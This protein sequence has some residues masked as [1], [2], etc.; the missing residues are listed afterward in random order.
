MKNEVLRNGWLMKLFFFWGGWDDIVHLLSN[1]IIVAGY[2]TVWE[3]LEIKDFYGGWYPHQLLFF[4]CSPCKTKSF[5]PGSLLGL[6]C[7]DS[8]ATQVQLMCLRNF[9]R[10]RTYRIKIADVSFIW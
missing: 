1:G 6:R 5:L 7:G 2:G 4:L 3:F 9:D 8:G 10:P